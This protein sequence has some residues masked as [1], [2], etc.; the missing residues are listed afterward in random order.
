MDEQEDL[1]KDMLEQVR[2]IAVRYI[3]FLSPS[4]P[5]FHLKYLDICTDSAAMSADLNL[6]LSC[7]WSYAWE[8]EKSIFPNVRYTSLM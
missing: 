3:L 2:K 4:L 5:F 7:Q 1:A 6:A 8:H